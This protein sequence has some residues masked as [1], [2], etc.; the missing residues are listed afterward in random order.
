MTDPEGSTSAE[1]SDHLY[2]DLFT[3]MIAGVAVHEIILDESGKPIDYRFLEV[4]PEFEK[5]TGLHAPDIVGRRAREV[6][7]DLEPEWLERYGR[8]A[9]T[10]VP[11]QFV[12]Y[13]GWLG[14][15]F[16][17]RAFRPAPGQFAA[18]FLDVTERTRA[19]ADLRERNAFTET[20]L[21][22]AG[23]GIAVY[24]RDLRFVVWNPAMAELSGLSAEQVI[25][26]DAQGLFGDVMGASAREDLARA[27]AG[28]SPVS[29]EFEYVIPR[30]GRRAWAIQTNRPH[31]NANGEVVG[32]VLSLRDITARHEIEEALRRSEEKFRA[33]FDS[34]GDAVAI[35]QPG[36]GFVEVNRMMCERLGYSRAELLTMSVADIDAPDS[37]ALLQSRV[38]TIMEDG[39]ARFEVTHVRRDG[40][41]I[42][43]EIVSRKIDFEGHPAILTVQRDI[44][45]RKRSEEAL[46]EQTRFLQ[47]LLDAIPIPIIAKDRESHV[48]LCN[49]AFAENGGL[50]REDVLGKRVGEI[51]IPEAEMHL[52]RD[53]AVL[54]D[55]TLQVY[56][57]LMPQPNGS[58][59][60]HVITKAP[61][62]SVE[63]EITGIV[64]AAI[65]IG[66]R[67]EAEQALRLTEARFRTLFECAGDAIFISDLSGRFTDANQTACDRLGYRKDELVG[68]RAIDVDTPESAAL[69]AE[70]LETLRERGSL[71]FETAHVRRD[72]TAIPV[73]MISTMIELGGQ[74]AV[75]SIARDISDR[76]RAESERAALE[77]QLRQSQKMEGIGQLAGGIAH[78]FNNL[79]TAISGY[80]SLALGDLDGGEDAHEDIEQIEHAADRA[81]ALTRQLL[82]FARRTVLQPEV[83]DLGASVRNLEP[84]LRRLIGEDLSLMT[85]TSPV[86]GAILADPGQMEQVIVN[87]VVNA[88]DAMPDGG[89]LTI[90]TGETELDPESAAAYTLTNPG[91]YAT[92]KVSDTGT[93]MSDETLSHVFEP[94]FTTKGPGKSTGLGLATVDGI[95]RQSGGGVSAES[96]LGRG[97]AFTV[98]L[99]LVDAAA[100]AAAPARAFP[101]AAPIRGGTILVVEDDHAVRGFATR[102]LEQAG[103]RVISA[104]DGISAL[105][106]AR[107]RSI[108]LLLTDV[109]MPTMSGREVADR[110]AS[111]APGI[112][113]LFV[114]GHDEKTIVRRGG[115]EAGIRY[116]A[117]P[118]TAEA[119]IGAVNDALA[120]PAD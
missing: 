75:L 4:N 14:R 105:D 31:F 98:F 60:R 37:A 53:K 71:A 43:T 62:R 70:R 39:Q 77:A 23:E 20:I 82:A 8:V 27:L 52:Q 74:P 120:A 1:D 58:P 104:A 28:E 61:L 5:L 34:V 45:E 92:L 10:G 16:L 18:L 76:K 36:G 64:T 110:L 108:D 19:E 109:V 11:D 102:V 26:A 29:S 85:V 48:Q 42:P 93:G 106:A 118:F 46:R 96:E 12:S 47:N 24:D 114:S 111:V 15:N 6:I 49:T 7:P 81:A 59:R 3:E 44:S 99:P 54:S 91:R 116:L 9:L 113:V 95:V 67:Y 50:R 17:V 2:R 35:Y 87:L 55:G 66:D 94:F 33:I 103:Y 97:S 63:G 25:G 115:L 78:D 117:K 41:L 89:V 13:S 86:R 107:G 119:L 112:R 100:R 30:T 101:S 21:A 40:G 65:D 72:G 32:V 88:R 83:V 68:M 69:V 51:G 80:A 73:E 79:L 38:D 90:E 56:E 57:A 22:S 84:M